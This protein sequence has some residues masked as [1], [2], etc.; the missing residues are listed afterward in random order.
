MVVDIGPREQFNLNTAF[1]DG[2]TIYT[3]SISGMNRVRSELKNEESGT[4][5]IIWKKR[6]NFIT[7]RLARLNPHWDG[8]RLFEET[9]RILIAE[10]Q[11]ITFNEYLP[12]LFGPSLFRSAGLKVMDTG[13]YEGY[14]KSVDPGPHRSTYSAGTN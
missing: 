4:L 1:I 6:H 5:N 8:R 7:S 11:H 9:R 10:I 2:S 14:D 3:S 13:Y 12:L